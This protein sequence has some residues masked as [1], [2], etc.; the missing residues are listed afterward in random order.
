[1]T[2]TAD[3]TDE[4]VP[5]ND[6]TPIFDTPLVT[7]YDVMAQQAIDAQRAR[8]ADEDRYRDYADEDRYRDY[9]GRTE[10][11]WCSPGRGQFFDRYRDAQ[12]AAE[13]YP[14]WPE[15]VTFERWVPEPE[16]VMSTELVV[17][18]KPV[19]DPVEVIPV[20]KRLRMQLGLAGVLAITACVFVVDLVAAALR[21]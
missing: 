13:Y 11:C 15:P 12:S 5:Y 10:Y 4:L 16:P 1:M 18:P 14:E 3:H 19:L 8:Y 21:Y 20:P 7:N 17:I 2:T 9:Q 6:G